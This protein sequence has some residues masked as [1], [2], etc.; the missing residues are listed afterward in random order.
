MAHRDEPDLE[1]CEVIIVDLLAAWDAG[2]DGQRSRLL[3]GVFDYIEVERSV[4][5]GLK[6][7]AVP[8]DDWTP[9]FESGPLEMLLCHVKGAGHG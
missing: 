4:N 9:F 2:D 7:V 5:G 6:I 8:R 1:W 3:A